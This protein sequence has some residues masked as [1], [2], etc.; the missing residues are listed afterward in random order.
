M[1]AMV[2]FV[3]RI[4]AFSAHVETPSVLTSADACGF[5]PLILTIQY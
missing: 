2:A 3:F 5:K 1:V 4:I